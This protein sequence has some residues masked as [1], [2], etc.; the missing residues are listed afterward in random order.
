MK[1]RNLFLATVAAGLFV[2]CSTDEV[3]TPNGGGEEA[4]VNISMAVT[5]GSIAGLRADDGEIQTAAEKQINRLTMFVFNGDAVAGVADRSDVQTNGSLPKDFIGDILLAEGTYDVLI[6]ANAKGNGFAGLTTRTA[7][8][9]HLEKIE[10]QTIGTEN[11]L[12]MVSE[13]LNRKFTAIPG[14]KITYCYIHQTGTDN[15]TAQNTQDYGAAA[16]AATAGDHVII[17]RQVARIQLDKLTFN[18]TGYTDA[19]FKLT[20]VYLVNMRPSTKLIATNNSYEA[21]AAPVPPT[22][23]Y[24]RG[25]PD[26]FDIVDRLIAPA[27]IKRQMWQASLKYI[28]IMLKH[29]TNQQWQW[30]LL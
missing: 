6:V 27:L 20:N 5:D 12:V 17:T 30:L 16:Y 29:T 25:N 2:A 23:Y 3:P 14:E 11:N 26:D 24:Y 10:D 22:P 4:M 8:A 28:L 18:P 15:V 19:T 7:V 21:T 13:V 1:L 9:A